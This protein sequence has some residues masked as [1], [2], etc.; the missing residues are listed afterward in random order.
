MKDSITVKVLIV[1][2]KAENIYALETLL[3]QDTIEFIH[4]IS[5]NEAL[6]IAYTG[7]IALIL[8]DVQMPEMDGYEVASILKQGKST[9][10]IPIIFVTALNHESKYIS[11]GYSKGAVDYLFKPLDPIITRSKVNSFINIY[12]QQKSL[13][14]AYAN[15]ELTVQERTSDLKIKNE[16]LNAEIEK[17]IAVESDLQIYN[18]KLLQLNRDLDQFVYSAS[19]DLKLPVANLEA[20][21]AALHEELDPVEHNA[22]DI[23]QMLDDSVMQLRKTLQ[24]LL[25]IIKQEHDKAIVLEDFECEKVLEEVKLSIAELIKHTKVII[26]T[27]FSGCEV[28]RFNRVAFKSILYNLITNSIKYCHPERSPVIS[29][30]LEKKSDIFVLSIK[31][32]GMGMSEEEQNKLFKLFERMNHSNAEGSGMGLF[33]VKNILDKYKVT[34]EVISNKNTGSEFRFTFSF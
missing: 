22:D 15:L 12:Q 4:A 26:E 25:D 11:E 6:K 17:R 30:L 28:F 27:D 5:G 1:D 3:A 32:N 33:I 13:E 20:L 16:E 21:I 2:D 19:H 31:D 8:L 14:L 7:D 24:D 9:Q 29:I 18:T 34:V 23:I 10:N